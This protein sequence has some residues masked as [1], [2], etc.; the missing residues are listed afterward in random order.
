MVTMADAEQSRTVV[1][2]ETPELAVACLRYAERIGLQVATEVAQQGLAAA[3]RE[4]ALREQD[5]PG[6]RAMLWQSPV[7]V[8]DLC[9]VARAATSTVL[10]VV[11][12]PGTHAVSIAIGSDL[13]IT[14]AHELEPFVA[15]LALLGAGARAPFAFPTRGLAA[16]D[17]TRIGPLLGGVGTGDGRLFSGDGGMIEFAGPQQPERPQRAGDAHT[18]ALALAALQRTDPNPQEVTSTVDDVDDAAVTDILFGPRRALS[19][20]ASKAVLLPYGLPL[21]DEEL[22]S[23][24]SRAAAE[25]TRLGYPVRIALASP[26][27]RIWDHPELAV[28]M[29]DSAAR[30]RDTYRTLTGL[31]SQPGGDGGRVLGATVTATSAAEALL[32]IHATPVAMGRV[33]VR[34]GFADPH[35]WA[36]EDATSLLLPAPLRGI[37]RALGRLSGAGLLRGRSATQRRERL[38]ALADL[39]L[40]LAALVNDR[41]K[42]IEA[43]E[44]R[45]VA[46]LLDGSLEVRE[47][48]ISVSD[49][50]ERSLAGN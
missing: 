48:C 21:P 12:S 50:F 18:V 27:L 6:S 9:E 28:D 37:E 31:A 41:R 29:V 49:S 11:G 2:C 44:L 45:P 46:M 30:V 38:A 25:A 7:P 5:S 47:A 15:C 36:A 22:C 35:G 4:R 1:I 43:V 42:E 3:L 13:G 33:L 16:L 19:D 39:L 24:A 34:L 26:D 17:R 40:R 32:S 20:P 14:V 8:V 10:G 23:S